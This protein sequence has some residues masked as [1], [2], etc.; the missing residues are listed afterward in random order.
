M[1]YSSESEISNKNLY[2][3]HPNYNRVMM[4]GI[5]M[6]MR[7]A[8]VDFKGYTGSFG[9]FYVPHKYSYPEA[10]SRVP[11]IKPEFRDLVTRT[12]TNAGEKVYAYIS[13]I[14]RPAPIDPAVV[15]MNEVGLGRIAFNIQGVDNILD[16]WTKSRPTKMPYLV[17]VDP[18][19]GG[20][21]YDSMRFGVRE[22]TLLKIHGSK[23]LSNELGEPTHK[24][25]AYLRANPEA[26]L[27]RV[28]MEMPNIP[29]YTRSGGEWYSYIEGRFD[30][31]SLEEAEGMGITPM[32]R[33]FRGLFENHNFQDT[34]KVV[35]VAPK[36]IVKEDSK[37]LIETVDSDGNKR[38]I[39]VKAKRR[40]LGR[41]GL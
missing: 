40:S 37:T 25:C 33:H 3:S 18:T 24:A 5:S 34:F 21:A 32:P 16:I 7:S 8:K 15:K 26:A 4:R 35:E 41:V 2:V 12:S 27:I 23:R 19:V 22:G 9:A 31:I 38:T 29:S 14:E 10:A 13:E 30:I 1:P 17:G 6:T 39:N 11:A 36:I 20:H 28:E